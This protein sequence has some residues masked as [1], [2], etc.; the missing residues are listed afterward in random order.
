MSFLATLNSPPLVASAGV[1]V[2]LGI[3]ALE[4]VLGVS[5]SLALLKGA[6]VAAFLTNV[7]AVS[8]PGRIDEQQDQAMRQGNLNPSKPNSNSTV[9][10]PLTTSTTTPLYTSARTRTLVNPSGW[11]FAIWGPIY[12]GE[13]AFVTVSTLAEPSSALASTILPQ[14]TAP[15]VAA[16]V[17]QS[18]W[19]A[20]FRPSYNAGW[21]NYVSVGLMAGTA[22]CYSQVQ[23]IGLAAAAAGTVPWWYFIPFSMHFGWTTAATL[24]NL[25]GSFAASTSSTSSDTTI[26]AMGHASALIATALGVGIT[27]TQVVPVY[28]LTLSWALAACANGMSKRNRPQDSDALKHGVKVQ[29]FI[30]GTGSAL[31]F[32]ASFVAATGVLSQ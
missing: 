19:C 4:G 21:H 17:M 31:C 26:I 9:T 27:M 24:V 15:F 11:A 30:C 12:L 7:G 28:G 5:S 14:I 18:L 3:P 32:I 23:S 16:N 10:T 25:N 1:A 29:R 22:Y 6:N 2:V 13:A 8:V 20:A